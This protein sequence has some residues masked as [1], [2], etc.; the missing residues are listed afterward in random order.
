ML[1][2][3]LRLKESSKLARTAKDV[4]TIV[5]TTRE[6]GDAL[7]ALGVDVITVVPDVHGRPDILAVLHELALRGVTR[8]LVEGGATVHNAFLERGTAY[9]LEIFRS[10]TVL[11]AKGHGTVDAL[12]TLEAGARPRFVHLCSRKLGVDV[13]ESFAVRA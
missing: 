11:G 5:F 4:P 10:P 1:D 13:L 3:K 9:R 12:S 7:K 2:G 8:L 6:G